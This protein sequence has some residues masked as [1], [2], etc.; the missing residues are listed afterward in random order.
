MRAVDAR[1]GGAAKGRNPVRTALFAYFTA[2]LATY[3][4]ATARPH[5][6]G[7]AQPGRPLV[8]ARGGD[9]RAGADRLRRGARAAAAG[10]RAEDARRG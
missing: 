1:V 3:G 2:M 6:V 7:R 10:L 8:R 9:R 5:G 4:F